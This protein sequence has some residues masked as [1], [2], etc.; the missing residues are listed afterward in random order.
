MAAAAT[1]SPLTFREVLKISALRRLWTRA[2]GKRLRGF[3]CDLCHI[4]RRFVPNARFRNGHHA[5]VGLLSSTA[6]GGEPDRRSFRRFLER[7]TNHDRKRPSP[8]G[9]IFSADACACVV[10]DLRDPP[11]CQHRVQFLH[12][13][14]IHYPA[15]TGAAP[16]IDECERPTSTGVF[17][18][19]D[20]Q[21]SYF[22]F[23]GIYF[24]CERLF[25]ARQRFVSVFSSDAFN[26]HHSL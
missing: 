21:S 9:S 11:A 26:A 1:P 4:Q 6:C 13:G 14:P 7:Q 20:H 3:S 25:L 22:R 5:R 19:A 8:G 15:D 2:I 17:F 16:R 23:A 18:D 24:R 12:A 10:A